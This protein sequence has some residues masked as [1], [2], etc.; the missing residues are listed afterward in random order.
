MKILEMRPRSYDRRIDKISRGRVRLVKEAV[1]AEI[2]DGSRVLEIGCGT[3]ELASMLVK[4]GCAVEG[5]DLS[6][7]MVKAARER[8]ET[9][10]L[11]DKFTVNEMGIEGMDSLP[12]AKFDAVVSTLVFSE[13]SD[14]ERRFA[15]KHA[16]RVLKRG[17]QI[18]VADEVVPRTAW[19][20]IIQSVV[21]LPLVAL[22][23]LVSRTSTRPI[24]DLVAE[25]TEAGFA[26]KK[27]VRS[28]GDAFA[29]V[30][31]FKDGV[32]N[33]VAACPDV[34]RDISIQV[35]EETS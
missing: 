11:K 35:K 31:G 27:E 22:T 24:A 14:D 6:P 2:I 25:M 8:I 17:G 15:L 7:S 12:D 9:E 33:D 32:A 19:R 4:R 20:R 34:D 13:L 28:H 1:A 30:V 10:I 29:I 3:G 5:F 16:A 18:I 23:Y 26:I 21:R